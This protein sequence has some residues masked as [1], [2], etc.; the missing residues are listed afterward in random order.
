MQVSE[1]VIT[2]CIPFVKVVLFCLGLTQVGTII[3]VLIGVYLQALYLLAFL[4]CFQW[5]FHVSQ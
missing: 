3:F 4:Y 1:N 2:E 5:R